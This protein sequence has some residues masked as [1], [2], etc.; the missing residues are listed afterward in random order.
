MFINFSVLY[1][2][3]WEWE[4]YSVTMSRSW[5]EEWLTRQWR[6]RDAGSCKVL[7]NVIAEPSP[8]NF[9]FC[10][11]SAHKPATDSETNTLISFR[12]KSLARCVSFAFFLLPLYS[13]FC[14]IFFVCTSFRI[15][16]WLG[17]YYYQLFFLTSCEKK[18]SGMLETWVRRWLE[19]FIGS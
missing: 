11:V 10:F 1:C 4:R 8:F 7:V 3:L 9:F 12:S 6:S 19:A 16:R 15:E 14:L 2:E 18:A 13:L 5:V 17:R